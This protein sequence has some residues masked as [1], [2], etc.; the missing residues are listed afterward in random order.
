MVV[1]RLAL[2]VCVWLSMG[3]VF[4]SY[5]LNSYEVAKDVTIL[6]TN[7]IRERPSE[8]LLSC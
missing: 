7:F 5:E 8:I 1:L 6:C 4:K 2:D 3:F